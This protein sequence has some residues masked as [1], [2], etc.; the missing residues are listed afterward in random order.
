VAKGEVEHQGWVRAGDTFFSVYFE[1]VVPPRTTEDDE[2]VAAERKAEALAAL[3]GEEAPL[4]AVLD[5]ARDERILQLLRSAVEEVQSL[6]EGTEGEE[7]AEGAP[8]LVALPKGSRLLDTLIDEGWGHRWGSYLTSRRPFREVRRHLR[9]FLIVLGT[10]GEPLYFRFY[11]PHALRAFLS[12]GTARHKGSFFASIDAVLAEG[13]SGEVVRLLPG[14]HQGAG[15]GRV[16]LRDAQLAEFADVAR[17]SFEHRAVRFLRNEVPDRID[18]LEEL[19][20]TG[21]KRATSYGL[22]SEREIIAYL[23]VMRHR[24]RDFD[25]EP[26][27]EAVLKDASIRNSTTRIV[28][29]RKAAFGGDAP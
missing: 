15:E 3:Q 20:H 23:Q 18:D 9:R 11:D 29:L 5:A 21:V 27:A 4:F 26:W 14:E 16:R 22:T 7:L 19:V 28:R 12:S 6:Y 17:A 2:P 25:G 1:G 13:W 24:G 8:Y 10:N